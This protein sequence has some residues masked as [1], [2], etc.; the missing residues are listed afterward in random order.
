MTQGTI[1]EQVLERALKDARFR[2]ELLSNPRTVLAEEYQIHLPEYVT[3]RVVEEAPN[4][5]TLVLPAREEAL[6]EL[7]DADL[8]A[9]SGGVKFSLARACGEEIPQ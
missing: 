4:T 7:S 2:Q 1:Q 8:E 5:L 9:V 6:E 3:V